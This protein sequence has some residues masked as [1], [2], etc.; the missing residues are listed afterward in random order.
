MAEHYA[1]PDDRLDALRLHL[2]ENAAG[3]SPAVV[4]ALQRLTRPTI[5]FYPAD[6][7]AVAA[8]A[9]YCG[10][11]PKR[12]VLTNALD[13]GILAITATGFAY[14]DKLCAAR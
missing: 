12:I 5:G 9:H 10:V 14:A 7:D 6:G 13:E 11:D 4:N 1:K 2:N 3:C 8:A